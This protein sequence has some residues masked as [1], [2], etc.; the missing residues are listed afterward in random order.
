MAMPMRRI[1]L[2]TVK[3]GLIGYNEVL[4]HRGVPTRLYLN[5]GVARQ[6]NTGRAKS[7]SLG[8]YVCQ[9]RSDHGISIEMPNGE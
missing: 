8:Q 4:V 3:Q 1:A 6:R 5:P 2:L 9:R 7:T